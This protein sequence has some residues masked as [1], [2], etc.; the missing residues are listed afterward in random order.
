MCTHGRIQ[1]FLPVVTFIKVHVVDHNTMNA[2][3][4]KACRHRFK[5]I[6]SFSR[7]NFLE[8]YILV[9]Q[10]VHPQVNICAIT[11][12]ENNNVDSRIFIINFT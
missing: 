12:I 11:R 5:Q 8:K 1:A 6:L 7:D 3:I 9:T 10:S 4:F 2:L